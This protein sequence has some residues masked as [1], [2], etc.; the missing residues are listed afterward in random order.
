[1]E[2]SLIEVGKIVNTHGINGEVK[3]TPWCDDINIF[4]DFKTLYLE[5][6]EKLEIKNARINK[7]VVILKLIGFNNINEVLNLMQKTVYVEQDYFVLDDNTFFIKDLIG[8]TVF[9]AD[10]ENVVYGKI[11]DITQAGGNDV[12]YIKDESGKEY[13]IPAI[14]DVVIETDLSKGKMRIRPLKGLFDAED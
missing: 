4:L 5:N 7:N 10:D 3:V 11:F 13:L 12:Y 14:A 9:D 1:M 8:L 2:N 6:N